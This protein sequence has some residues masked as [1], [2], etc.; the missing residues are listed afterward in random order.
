MESALKRSTSTSPQV[1]R[2]GVWL[3]AHPATQAALRE[4]GSSF[5]SYDTLAHSTS[6]N[7]LDLPLPQAL[8]ETLRDLSTTNT[9]NLGGACGR[10]LG[11]SADPHLLIRPALRLLSLRPSHGSEWRTCCSRGV[12]AEQKRDQAHSLG[13]VPS[14]TS[15][16]GSRAPAACESERARCASQATRSATAV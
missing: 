12:E 13:C 1:D 5:I 9:L 6:G 4:R 8:A 14:A 2:R 3:H 7:Q 11:R 16:D 15:G 10:P